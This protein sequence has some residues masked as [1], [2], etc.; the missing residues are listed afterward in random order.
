MGAEE[1]EIFELMEQPY[2][3]VRSR[4]FEKLPSLLFA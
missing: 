2:W 1:K 4:Y 3:K